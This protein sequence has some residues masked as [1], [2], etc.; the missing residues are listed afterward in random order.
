MKFELLSA[1]TQRPYFSSLPEIENTE[2][3][4][5]KN[6]TSGKDH[7]YSGL[8]GINTGLTKL[9]EVTGGWHNG[10][11][12]L[13]ASRPGMGKT[14]MMIFFA[15]I[16]A[17]EGFPVCI[18]SLES[19]AEYITKRL[20]VSSSILPDDFLVAKSM[21]PSTFS[22][23][24]KETQK[25]SNLPIYID[26]T[27]DF[28]MNYIREHAKALKEEGKCSIIFIDYLQIIDLGVNANTE[29]QIFTE[30]LIQAKSISTELNVPLVLLSQL[31][32]RVELKGDPRP[33]LTDLPNYQGTEPIAD[34]I[35]FLYRPEYY[36]MEFDSNGKSLKGYGEIIIAKNHHGRVQDIPFSYNESMTRISDYD[37]RET[38]S[39]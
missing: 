3:A 30:A 20:I 2:M 16:A 12:I 36:N 28:T 27:T 35:A 25:L 26:D 17:I 18:Y 23:L 22:E 7:H 14:Q 19:S 33:I 29:E 15:K 21:S 32:D 9:N 39:L 4:T 8:S 38:H 11:L 6:E 13:L 1:D 37:P 5:L 24:L 10:D 31:S 34:I